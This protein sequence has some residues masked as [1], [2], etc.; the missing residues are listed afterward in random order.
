[1]VKGECA[2]LGKVYFEQAGKILK[3]EVQLNEYRTYLFVRF[4]TEMKVSD[5]IEYFQLLKHVFKKFIYRITGQRV[6]I[7]S[8]LPTYETLEKELYTELSNYKPIERLSA[9][10][11][12]QIYY[13]FSIDQKKNCLKDSLRQWKFARA[14]FRMKQDTL[15]LNS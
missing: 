5:P 14:S 11:I 9:Q 8:V 6:P 3:D 1:M 4:T 15:R 12:G 7:S 10:E 2:D 13:Y